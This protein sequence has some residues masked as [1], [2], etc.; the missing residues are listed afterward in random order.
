M[1]SPHG[2]GS[3]WLDRDSLKPQAH[4]EGADFASGFKRKVLEFLGITRI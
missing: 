4:E 1:S 3:L 2:Q